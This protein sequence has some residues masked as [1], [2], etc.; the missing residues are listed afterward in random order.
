MSQVDRSLEKNI[1]NLYLMNFFSNAQF[2]LVVFTLF[3]LSKGFTMQQF[4]LI[5]SAYALV[6]LLME[7]PTRRVQRQK[8]S[9]MEFNCRLNRW[10]AHRAGHYPIAFI[11]SRLNRHGQRQNYVGL[12]FNRCSLSAGCS[13]FI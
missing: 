6:A 9:Q 12:C 11:H 7:I 8:K 5:E 3:L 4:F 1:R 10:P 2:H 13:N